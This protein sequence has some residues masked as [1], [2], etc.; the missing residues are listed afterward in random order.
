MVC[1]DT[2]WVARHL[3]RNLIAVSLICPVCKGKLPLVSEGKSTCPAVYRQ[4]KE[5]TSQLKEATSQLAFCGMHNRHHSLPSQVK[6]TSLGHRPDL[7]MLQRPHSFHAHVK[8][9][10]VIIQSVWCVCRRVQQCRVAT[11]WW[12]PSKPSP[13]L[14][15]AP[16]ARPL[17]PRSVP[18]SDY[19]HNSHV[20]SSR[21]QVHTAA[22][23]PLHPAPLW[24]T[25]HQ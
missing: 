20:P 6:V 8:A 19:K 1:G 25:M 7:S 24:H 15:L 17:L 16:T 22:I 12:A 4:L 10:A 18:C 3:H 11:R 23:R 21:S 2:L 14:A 9:R 13:P 5:A